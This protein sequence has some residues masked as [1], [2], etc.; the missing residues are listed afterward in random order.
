VLSRGQL[1]EIGGSFRLPEIFETSGARLREVG[2]TN[3][4]RLADYERAI[5]PQ[6][7]ALMRV[8][9]SNYRIIGFTE[10]VPIAALA[11]LAKAHGLWTIDDIGSG[12]LGPGR[13]PMMTQ[14]P[15][16]AESLAAGADLVLC[17][18]DKLLGGPQCG[19]LFGSETAIARVAADPLMR[20]VRVDKMT[21]A[22][23]GATLQ[24]ASDADRAQ[25]RI[26]LWAFLTTP[27]ESLRVRAERLA[28]A[29]RS[30]MR[31]NASIIESTAFLGGGS[32][33]LEPVRTVAVRIEPPFAELRDSEDQFARKLRV[34]DPAV[35]ARIHDGSVLFDFRTV[36]EEEDQPL[37]EAVR[38]VLGSSR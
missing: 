10:Q 1:I 19:L 34:G 23:L 24:L 16:V 21:L 33:P 20:A 8:H 6:T 25:R 37:L 29:L 3:K 13:P 36:F 31:L 11:S 15:T 14:E 35:V 32:A 18:G 2:T 38:Q 5:G 26:P 30:E 7:A 27:M 28:E 4:T 12:A 9:S 17:S 22:A